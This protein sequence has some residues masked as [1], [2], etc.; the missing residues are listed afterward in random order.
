[1]ALVTHTVTHLADGVVRVAWNGTADYVSWVFVNG[2]IHDGPRYFE[3]VL[4]RSVD[5]IVPDP[6][7]IE[8]HE[9]PEGEGVAPIAIPL[10]R[11]PLIWWRANSSAIRYV[12]YHT[13]PGGV[14]TVIGVI[15]HVVGDPFYEWRPLT[16]L[17]SEGG[18]WGALR[19]EA[20][21]ARDTESVRTTI[22]HFIANVPKLPTTLGV[23]GAAGVFTLTLGVA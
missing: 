21:N 1:M 16:D 12:V 8:V 6:Y 9:A 3:A 20:I 17:R 11:Q 2:V 10:Q 7:R 19:V 22:P 14:E 23:A 4:P 13:P 15:P 18:R 5:I